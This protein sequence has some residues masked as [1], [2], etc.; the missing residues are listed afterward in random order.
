MA[1][2]VH[3]RGKRQDDNGLGGAVDFLLANAR[4]VLGLGG[5]AVLAI[6][7]LVVKRLIDRATSSPDEDDTK[8]EQKSIEESW[9]DLS[10]IK[11]VPKPPKK[12]SR[13]DLSESLLSPSATLP[14]QAAETHGHPTS[15]ETPQVE[16]RTLLCLTFQ[17]K[18]LSYYRNHVTIPES[19]VALGKQLAKDICIELQ[20]FLQNKCPELPFGSMFLSGSLCDDLQVVAADHVCFMLPLVFETTLWSLIPGED[21]IVK[22]PQFWMI[23]RTDL[24]YFPRGSSPW[25]RFIVGRY[26]SS[27]VINEALH[28]MLVASVNWPAIG[29][30]LECLIRPVMASE[31]LKLEVTHYETQLNITLCPVTEAGGKVL[32]AKPPK[33][34]VENLWRQSFYRSEVSKLKDLDAADSGAR[35][36]CLKILKGVCKNHPFLSKLTGSHLTHVL[37]HLSESESD[38]AEEALAARFQ[39]V[40]EALVG[41]LETGFLPCY[42]NSQI[43][44]FCELLEEEID[45]MGYALY[46]AVSQ[47]D[48]LFLQQA[49][50]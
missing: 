19:D 40:L 44:L 36:C 33:G 21:T 16:S 20:S 37:L 43:N 25:D 15:L 39:H 7:T 28:K 22:D 27:N 41:Y 46:S 17:E 30:M 10:L 45:E 48:L 12:Q 1:D 14:T 49:D 4:L 3:K 29:S 6:A 11:A 23:R 5:A 2:L 26:L 35:Q 9:Q 47:P 8:A 34:L 31:E 38:W 42:F 18:L 50:K 13:A 32:L 24:E